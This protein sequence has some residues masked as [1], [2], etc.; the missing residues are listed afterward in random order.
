MF[1]AFFPGRILLVT[2]IDLCVQCRQT[3][4][5]PVNRVAAAQLSNNRI[6]AAQ[7]FLSIE[8]NGTPDCSNFVSFE[9][10]KVNF[11]V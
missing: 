3:G 11:L 7:Q 9:L 5:I 10:H 6:A 4:R 2:R 8:S 1:P